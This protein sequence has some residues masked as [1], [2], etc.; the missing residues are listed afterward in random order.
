MFYGT[1]GSYRNNFTTHR[2]GSRRGAG[3]SK[4]SSRHRSH[5]DSLLGEYLCGINNE[6]CNL[7]LVLRPFWDV[8]HRL[9]IDDGDG[10]LV[11]DARIVLPRILVK[12]TLKTLIIMHQGAS[13]IRQRLRLS[14][15]WPHIDTDIAN[16]ATQCEKCT[17][18]PPSLPAEAFQPHAPS[19]RPFEFLHVDIGED[20]GRHF[21]VIIYQFSGWP[22]VTMFQ[23]KNTT[24]G[25]LIEAFFLATG[26]APVKLWKDNV[27]F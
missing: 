27:H 1:H 7:P 24:L 3:E 11:I 17:S 13:K 16:A 10:M 20:D 26:R 19:S 18:Q 21:L 15:Y 23:K 2:D 14:L 5:H 6:K 8:R 25:R 12:E 4:S 9:A 22:H